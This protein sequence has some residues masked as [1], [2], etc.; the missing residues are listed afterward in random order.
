MDTEYSDIGMSFKIRTMEG[1]KY[2][3]AYQVVD[4]GDD[5]VS[6]IEL[7]SITPVDC[8]FAKYFNTPF[9]VMSYFCCTTAYFTAIIV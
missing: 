9:P 6:Q 4:K 8:A 5:M 3:H 1:L 2:F 7:K